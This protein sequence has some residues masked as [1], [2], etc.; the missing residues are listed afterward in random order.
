MFENQ[1][2]SH[3]V[4]DFLSILVI[5]FPNVNCLYSATVELF[6]NFWAFR[7]KRVES[8]HLFPFLLQN[9]P[10]NEMK[11]PFIVSLGK[12]DQTFTVLHL[13]TFNS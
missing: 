12:R 5:Q 9:G 10:S 6:M 1:G 13:S 4:C 7:P 8:R 11:S 2:N 3:L